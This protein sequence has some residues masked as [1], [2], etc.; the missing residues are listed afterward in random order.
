MVSVSSCDACPRCGKPVGCGMKAGLAR[1]WCSD[2]P[3]V[4]KVPA[5][6]QGVGCYCPD[7]LKIMVEAAAGSVPPASP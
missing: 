6:G 5:A 2:Y 4:L 7:C 1:C 3:P